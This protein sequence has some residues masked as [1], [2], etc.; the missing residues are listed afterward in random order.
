MSQWNDYALENEETDELGRGPF[1]AL[2]AAALL[3]ENKRRA[4]IIGLTGAWGTGK[5]TVANFVVQRVQTADPEIIIIRFEP[6]M[7]STSE[8]LAREFFKELGK[9]ALPKDNSKESKE[10]RAR[11]YKYTALTLDALALTSGALEILQVPF[12]GLASKAFKG[13]QKAIDLAAKGLEAQATQ[14]TLREARDA[15]SSALADLEKPIIVVIDDIDRLNQEEI[16]TVFQ[17]IKACAD[18]PNIR[19]LLLYDRDQVVHALGDSVKDPDAFLEKIVGQVFDLPF[20]TKKQREAILNRH[21]EAL[22]IDDLTGNPLERLRELISG[23]LLPGLPTVRHVKRFI[24]T[25]S[26]LLPGVIVNGHRNIDPADFLALEFIR[27]F[28]PELYNVL[29]DEETPVPGGVVFEMAQS[30]ELMRQ[31]KEARESTIPTDE[32][33][34]MLAATALASLD[35]PIE[36]YGKT[37][38]ALSLQK[39]LDR[40]F[41]S[42]HWKPVYLGFTAGRAALSQADWASVR[43][44]LTEKT[45]ERKWLQRL[46]NPE[47]RTVFAQAAAD[48]ANE[49]SLAEAK[50]LL[51][52]IVVW[53]EKPEQDVMESYST[54]MGAMRSIRLIGTACLVRISQ[55]GD[56]VEVVSD[57]L[58]RT[59]AI[60][61]LGFICGQ[62]Y[63]QIRKLGTRGNWSTASQFQILFQRLTTMFRDVAESDKVFN[64]PTLD[65]LL[66][67]WKFLDAEHTF[68]KWLNEVSNSP[69]RLAHYV[70]HVMGPKIGQRDS[71]GVGQ[72]TGSAFYQALESLDNALLTGDGKI[73]RNNALEAMKANSRFSNNDELNI[74][75]D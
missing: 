62:E 16:R 30:N 13:S 32:T 60:G 73:A 23:V 4:T 72:T 44:T 46:S 41:A 21:L 50:E 48:R 66:N 14:P 9:A 20:A 33:R 35:D 27:Q 64:Q 26:S 25:L 69:A 42:E 18:F 52:T 43:A 38:H 19:Y 39:H 10:K 15:L 5:S 37:W 71:T 56:A 7:V 59:D 67:A 8:A 51:E 22:Q 45:L 47:D 74:I 24:G 53:R 28:V 49:L 11:F 70:N 75:I 40:R 34:K 2:I 36:K 65:E 1:A 12:A 3:A 54:G 29:R 57:M 55:D 63:S 6:W 17:I 61:R 58:D 31:R 68:S